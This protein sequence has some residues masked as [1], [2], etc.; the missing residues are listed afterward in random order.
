MSYGIRNMTEDIVEQ[1]IN[2]IISLLYSIESFGTILKKLKH[3]WSIKA[4]REK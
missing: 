1:I 3:N 2:H 4:W